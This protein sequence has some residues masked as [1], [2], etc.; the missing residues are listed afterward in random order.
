MLKK[1][2][3]IEVT[4]VPHEIHPETPQ[5]GRAMTELFN[6]FDI[7]QVTM[8]CREKG[9]RYGV[10]FG[11]LRWLS[12]TH[13]ALEAAE[14]AREKGRYD[15]FHHNVF[16]AYFT[17]GRDI[18]DMKVLAEI[19]AQSGVDPTEMQA[20]LD[21]KVYSEKVAQGSVEARAAG[22]TAIPTFVIEGGEKITGAVN[23]QRF[24]EVLQAV[25]ER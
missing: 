1:E 2:F 5:E 24:R 7:D 3:D 13:L 23:E 21:G 10:E 8:A 4:W 25:A 17:D 12:N 18:G 19:A 15:E 16:K 6:Q 14:Y 9:G 22:V 11:D 20:S